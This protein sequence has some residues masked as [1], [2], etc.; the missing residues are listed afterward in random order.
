MGRISSGSSGEGVL[1]RP[2]RFGAEEIDGT[3]EEDLVLVL[4]V[5][6]GG[7]GVVEA[8]EMEEEPPVRDDNREAGEVR[9]V[10]ETR[11]EA[12][13][14]GLVCV[15]ILAFFLFSTSVCWSSV[16]SLL[17]LLIFS[18]VEV[19]VLAGLVRARVRRTAGR[20][21]FVRSA[22]SFSVFWDF[23]K[24]AEILGEGPPLRADDLDSVGGE[25]ADK[26][27]AD[28][29]VA[30]LIGVTF[31]VVVAPGVVLNVSICTECCHKSDFVRS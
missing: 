17:L 24:A 21:P 7:E 5:F 4:V 14:V 23:R 13:D 25:R 11:W 3:G 6:R 29:G 12:E 18:L 9:S 16:L 1:L 10:A 2:F 15:L 26:E 20:A 22:G 27:R 30:F 31:L 19:V 8:G 28:I